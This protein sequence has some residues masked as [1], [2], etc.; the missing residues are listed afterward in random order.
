[1]G[2]F[3][4][5]VEALPQKAH[6]HIVTPTWAFLK[7]AGLSLQERRKPRDATGGARG[8]PG[9]QAFVRKLTKR[10]QFPRKAH[11]SLGLCAKNLPSEKSENPKIWLTEGSFR[12]SDSDPRIFI[13]RFQTADQSV[14][15]ASSKAQ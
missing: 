8:C 4:L 5:V 7:R 2:A 12:V 9:V 15:G 6:C 10:R 3:P 13:P 11:V 14:F 1:V